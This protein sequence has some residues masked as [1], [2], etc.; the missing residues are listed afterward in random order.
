MLATLAMMLGTMERLDRGVLAV[1]APEGTFLSWRSLPGDAPNLGFDVLRNGKKLNERPLTGATCF[2]DK[3]GRGEY[4]VRAAGKTE[5]ALASD[6]PYLSI[7]LKPLPGYTANDG[8]VG[9]LDGDGRLELVIHRT[10]R[11]HDNSQK[12]ETDPPILEAYSLDG[13]FLWRINLGKNMRDGAHYTPF[14]VADLDGDGRAEVACRT[15]DGTVDGKG[16]VIGDAKADWRNRDGYVLKGPEFLTVFDGRTGAVRDTVP[17]LPPRHPKPDATPEDINAVWGDA[18]GNRVDRLLAGLGYFDGQHPSLLFTRGYYTRFFAAAWDFRG[19]KLVK[20]WTFDSDDGTPGNEKFRGQGDHSLSIADVDGDGKDEVIYGGCAL[21]DDGKGLYSTGL[22][23]G[24]ALHVSDLD[25]TRPGLEVFNIH[26]HSKTQTGV[27]F[28]DART[29]EVLWKKMS[30]D[31]ARGVALDIDPRYP[32]SECWSSTVDTDDGLWNC[33]GEVISKI[34]PKSCNFGVLWDGDGLSEI[35]DK[36]LITKWDWR[37]S[38]EKTLLEAEGCDSNNGTKSIPVLCADIL[39]DWREEVIWRTLD[40]KELRIYTTTIPTEHRVTTLLADRQYREAVAWQNAGY[41]QPPHPS[42]WL[43]G[44]LRARPKPTLWIIG[45]STVRNGGGGGQWGWGEPLAER[46]DPERIDVKNRAIGGRSSR[47]FLTEG[48][49]DA[50]LSEAKPGDYLLMQFGHNDPGAINDDSR[51]RGTIRGVG[52]ETQEIDNLLTKRH[53]VVHTYGWYMRK[54]VRDAKA[55]GMHPIVLSYVPRS[56]QPGK[57]IETNP[58][59]TSYRLWSKQV[60]ESEGAAFM[61]LYALIWSAYTSMTAETIRERY[62]TTADAT[63][64]S[65]AGA[66]LNADKVVEGLRGSPLAKYL[67]P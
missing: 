17:Y 15:A 16:R 61:D 39:G 37:T 14:I 60:A 34:K 3:G 64:T 63:H 30:P 1:A 57:P 6:K 44:M 48:R 29:G 40:G 25:P 35:L 49:W 19:G 65:R 31:V 42:F 4:A 20:R 33:K 32:G 2:L 66:E 58:E 53:E 47:T 43:S 51:A 21:D 54:Y 10:G 26:E 56:P 55:K 50:I 28:R 23:H 24:D 18:Y 13:K 46:F 12:G 52:E 5:R 11:T 62:F 36:N 41:N 27:T 67:Y 9:D 59:P 38:T 8:S 45:D 7:P 22:G